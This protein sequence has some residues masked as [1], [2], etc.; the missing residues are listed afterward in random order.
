[1]VARLSV[2]FGDSTKND[3]DLLAA[4]LRSSREVHGAPKSSPPARTHDDISST[5]N[6]STTGGEL[7]PRETIPSAGRVCAARI[8]PYRKTAGRHPA[9]IHDS[10]PRSRWIYFNWRHVY[11]EVYRN[12]MGDENRSARLR[13]GKNLLQLFS[14]CSVSNLKCFCICLAGK[15][16]LIYFL[17]PYMGCMHVTRG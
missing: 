8:Q 7:L 17:L 11:V 10:L 3:G 9:W 1:M 12:H 5:R 14:L 4:A 2:I 16:I 6:Q 13:K 15:I